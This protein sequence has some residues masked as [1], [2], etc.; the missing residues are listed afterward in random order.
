MSERIWIIGVGADGLGGL[1]PEL[2]RVIAEA[3]FVAAGRRQ[4]EWL[5]HLPRETFVIRDNVPELI[6][7]L[8]DWAAAGVAVVLASGD[9]LFFGVGRALC[10]AL[11]REALRVE[12]AV[13]SMQLAFAR[14]G[15]SWQG[16]EIASIHGRDLATE[17]LPVLGRRR[18]GIFSEDGSS[19][20]AVAEFFTRR[21]AADYR[22]W[23]CEQLG[24][25]NEQLTVLSLE[26][27]LNRGVAFS[28]LNFLVLERQQ[29]DSYFHELER[30]RSLAPGI[31]DDEFIRPDTGPVLMTHQE[32]RSVT[33]AKLAPGRVPG[34]T[35][36]DIGAGI[37]TI[38]VESALLN[39]AANVLAVERSNHEF[40]LLARNRERFGAYNVQPTLGES[41]AALSGEIAQPH[42]V[43]IGGSGSQLAAT[44]ELIRD[45]LEPH[46]RLVA[47][48]V[49]IE[50]LALCLSGCD[51]WRW[52]RQVVQIAVARSDRLADLTGLRPERPVW[53][54]A[55][56]KSG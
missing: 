41:P 20:R 12:P 9:P 18:I 53:V 45:R 4:L 25:P 17:L 35:I 34:G 37:G 49:T 29:P 16:A 54:L 10:E 32:V 24:T 47:N 22:V 50:N 36:W 27:I 43:F 38:S 14:C 2:R 33:L 8:R 39:P 48:F 28:A 23:V 11:G 56:E 5:D 31:P 1:R 51:R 42:S 6:A 15:M 7:R 46:G 30:L 52:P 55:T 26:E 44:L 13:S 21:G 40:A 3:A 19:P